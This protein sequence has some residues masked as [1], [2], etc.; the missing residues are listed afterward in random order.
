MLF[1]LLVI[2]VVLWFLGYVHIS[3]LV[4]PDAVLFTVNGQP[5]TLWSVLI[6]AVVAWLIGV[7]P[8]PFREIASVILVLWVLSV[9]G[10]LA[11]A[12]LSNLLVLAIIVGLVFY[13]LG[14][15]RYHH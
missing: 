12:G 4:V 11:F 2:L 9:L 1:G 15:S 10:I 5:I 8:R 6:L 3:G 7:L 14:G 13:L